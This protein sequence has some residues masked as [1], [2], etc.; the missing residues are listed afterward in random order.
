LCGIN[1][2]N[3]ALQQ[4]VI[5]IRESEKYGEAGCLQIPSWVLIAW[6]ELHA[7]QWAGDNSGSL[8]VSATNMTV[9]PQ[10][11]LNHANNKNAHTFDSYEHT[12]L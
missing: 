6:R 9:S 4:R 10:Y 2:F 7:A 5:V 1:I 12:P 3:I 11:R 8:P